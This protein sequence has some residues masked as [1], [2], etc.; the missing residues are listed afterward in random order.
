MLPDRL[1]SVRQLADPTAQVLH[2]QRFDPFGNVL[3]QA[4]VDALATPANR[5]M[6]AAWS[7]CGR[8]ITITI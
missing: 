3:E 2:A 1:G 4:G 5:P 7:I 8:G 6:P